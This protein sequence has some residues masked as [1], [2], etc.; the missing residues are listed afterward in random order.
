MTAPYTGI[1][2]P[3]APG[4]QGG[5][6]LSAER[7]TTMD[8]GIL[9]AHERI[10]ELAAEVAAIDVPYVP[11]LSG[12][13]TTVAM[14]AADDALD[15]RVDTLEARPVVDSPD[16][17][18]AAAAA[19]GHAIAGVTGLQAALDGK[20]LAQGRPLP[21]CVA[22]GAAD[23]YT[24]L[25]AYIA[26]LPA[27]STVDL[28][29]RSYR[30]TSPLTLNKALTVRNGTITAG[31]HNAITIT[32]SGVTLGPALTLVRSSAP[33][34]VS[35][36]ATRA[37]VAATAPFRS[38]EVDY[39]GAAQSC[40]YLAHGQCNGTVIRG[41][42]M[43]N[44]A[45]HQDSAGVYAAAGS[46]GNLDISIEN[47]T[48]SGACAQGVVL[49]D[50]K[51]SV[52]RNNRITG[53]TVLPQV[54]VTGW[55]A[56]GTGSVYRAR[57]ATGSPGTTGPTTDR[58]DGNTRVVRNGAT[59]LVEGT[60]PTNPGTNQ[61]GTSGGYLYL[62]LG[63][64]DPSTATITSDIVSGY[65]VTLYSTTA[66]F[67]DMSENLVAQN[68]IS[69]VE[70]FG[71]YMQLSNYA[72]T[73]RNNKT[74]SNTL[75][76]VCT[77]GSQTTILPF[78]GLAWNGGTGCL[79]LGDHIDTPGASGFAVP[80]FYA[81]DAS[82]SCRG[83]AVGVT[84]TNSFGEGFRVTNA[85][86]WTYSSCE[87]NNN[88]TSGF[89][90]FFPASAVV[91]GL[92]LIGCR[93][94]GNT[95]RGIDLDASTTGAFATATIT[96][97][98]F[99]DNMQQGIQLSAMR[100]TFVVG[101]QLHNNGATSFHQIRFVGDCKNSGFDNLDLHHNL[102]GASLSIAQAQTT[103]F[104]YGNIAIPSNMTAPTLGTNQF[105]VGG[106][107]GV[108]SEFAGSGV[109][110]IAGAVGDRYWRRDGGTGARLYWCTVAGGAGA[111][112]WTAIL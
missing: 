57:M 33:S 11:D 25:A 54:T 87:A 72:D 67:S 61:W 28:G 103:D 84:V 4:Q 3:W 65:G 39:S 46:T 98:V 16:D 15:S 45:A 82:V 86:H 76:N 53:M 22:D 56:T 93:G 60:T 7:F 106:G 105:R 64:A 55:S 78:A 2:P 13:A 51:R 95:L 43:V 81:S 6:P 29:G 38:Y 50:S 20:A 108:G 109:P 102:A 9:A 80:G 68:I 77:K 71:I 35:T 63:G 48:I 49:F 1:D 70:S 17:I 100:D 42:S 111:A 85:S 37:L 83:K 44:N 26:G 101:T 31:S 66:G 58:D 110:T 99:H 75:R 14:V 27:S 73:C 10:T 69:N 47:V 96:G 92:E 40:V 5:T 62:D 18:G 89:R 34:V 90:A 24:P 79:S 32:A 104:Y 97:G 8:D 23:D 36:A 112:T 91:R 19:H 59:L 21:G 74:V 107:P 30:V 12:L 41:G 94:Y 88:A 52:I